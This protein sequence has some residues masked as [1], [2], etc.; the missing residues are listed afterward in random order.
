MIVKINGISIKDT[1]IEMSAK[2][3]M[4]AK[5]IEDY[6]VYSGNS[7]ADKVVE[8]IAAEVAQEYLKVNKADLVKTINSK[9]ITDGIQ[10]KIIEGFS[11][12]SR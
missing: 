2:I 5:E 3:V 8:K 9:E 10:I 12:Q 4:T 11:L 6:K 1:D 7:L